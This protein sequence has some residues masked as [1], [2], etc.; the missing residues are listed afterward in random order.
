[1]RKARGIAASGPGWSGSNSAFGKHHGP[2]PARGVED[3]EQVHEASVAS[4]CK[5]GYGHAGPQGGQ[6]RS[7]VALGNLHK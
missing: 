7:V 6:G 5:D 4:K 2:V 1:M 3:R